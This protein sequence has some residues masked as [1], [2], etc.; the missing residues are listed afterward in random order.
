MAKLVK[1]TRKEIL[2]LQEKHYKALKDI[3][4]ALRVSEESNKVE[5]IKAELLEKAGKNDVIEIVRYDVHLQVEDSDEFMRSDEDSQCL[6]WGVEKALRNFKG[7]RVAF[8]SDTNPF[9][10]LKALDKVKEQIEYSMNE[11]YKKESVARLRPSKTD[12]I[13]SDIPF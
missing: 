5:E 9:D 10:V 13:S 2:E 6:M 7:I 3:D 4:R 1:K 11:N 8:K 12:S